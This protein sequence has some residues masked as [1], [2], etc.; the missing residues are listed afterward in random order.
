MNLSEPESYG[1]HTGGTHFLTSCME[2]AKTLSAEYLLGADSCVRGAES[3]AFQ[4]F[5]KCISEHD[6]EYMSV[7]CEMLLHCQLHSLSDGGNTCASVLE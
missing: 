7:H 1:I 6:R 2:Q 4:S 5:A 3:L